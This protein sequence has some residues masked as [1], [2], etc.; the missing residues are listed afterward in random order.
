MISTTSAVFR[1][2]VHRLMLSSVVTLIATFSL[3]ARADFHWVDT[4]VQQGFVTL[5]HLERCRASGTTLNSMAG[6]LDLPHQVKLHLARGMI[7]DFHPS[8]FAGCI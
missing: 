6:W 7:A 2:A 8:L 1:F 5:H 4:A 3:V